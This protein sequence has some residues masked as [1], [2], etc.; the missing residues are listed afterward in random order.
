MRQHYYLKLCV[1]LYES[2]V[3]VRVSPSTSWQRRCMSQKTPPET[4]TRFL[5]RPT[6]WYLSMIWFS[7]C[8]YPGSESGLSGLREVKINILNILPSNWEYILN[9]IRHGSDDMWHV[10]C[11]ILNPRNQI[12]QSL[13]RSPTICPSRWVSW[14]YCGFCLHRWVDLLRNMIH[15]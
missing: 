5:T 2:I 15:P 9:N 8:D 12:M 6:S 11:P 7:N 14:R 10:R 1:E 13:W 4:S 3:N